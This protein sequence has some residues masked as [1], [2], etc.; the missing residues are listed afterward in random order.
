MKRVFKKSV[1]ILLT[2]AIL[3]SV[4]TGCGNPGQ[5]AAST[6]AEISFTETE[7]GST[8]AET[9]STEAEAPSTGS[10]QEETPAFESPITVTD[11][12]GREVR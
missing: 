1:S 7:T 5:P 9:A 2:G 4:L 12:I 3:A 6:E 10:S 11:Q 8:G